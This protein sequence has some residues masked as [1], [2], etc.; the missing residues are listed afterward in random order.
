MLFDLR[1][2]GRRRTVQAIYL[3]LAILMGGGLVLFGVGGGGNGGLLD[4]FKDSNGNVSTSDV[5]R[6]NVQAA[7]AA[8]RARPQDAKAWENLARR[9]FQQ[10]SSEGF[11]Q[12]QQ[13]YTDEGKRVL[14]Q[15]DQAWS[16]ALTLTDKPDPN[17]ARQMVQ[18]YASTGLNEPAKAV[19]AFEIILPTV[20]PATAQLYANYATL[21]YEAGQTRKADLASKKA[22]SL[23]S[24]DDREQ[25]KSQ[26]DAAK[27]AAPQAAATTSVPAATS[28]A[29]T[30]TPTATATTSGG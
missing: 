8:V 6:K 20:E 27:A 4:A 24:T 12:T 18:V 1:G 17:V 2:R 29:T 11:D 16:R 19:G 7:E 22:L 23:A 28:T 3:T 14:A 5:F 21:A 15:A 30:K 10:A 13:V 25:I 26:L 9:R